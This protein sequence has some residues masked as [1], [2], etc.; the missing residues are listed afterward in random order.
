MT[1][2]QMIFER[3]GGGDV[4]IFL[5]D[6]RVVTKKLGRSFPADILSFALPFAPDPGMTRLMMLR[7]GRRSYYR[8][9][10]S[11][12]L[13]KRGWRQP[14]RSPRKASCPGREASSGPGK[15]CSTGSCHC[16]DPADGVVCRAV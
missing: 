3:P 4:S 1:A 7:I 12:C 11:A 6:G 9:G 5:V 8:V 2:E 14:A 15:S 13:R 10:S 16:V